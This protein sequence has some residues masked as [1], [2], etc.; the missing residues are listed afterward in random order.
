MR[1]SRFFGGLRDE[2]EDLWNFLFRRKVVYSPKTPEE[3]EEINALVRY[4]DE[5]KPEV[6]RRYEGMNATGCPLPASLLEQYHPS[7]FQKCSERR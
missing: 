3:A 4:L 5:V 1:K 6:E 2:V 7:L